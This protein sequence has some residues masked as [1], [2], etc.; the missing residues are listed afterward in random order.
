MYMEKNVYSTLAIYRHKKE[1]R[2]GEQTLTHYSKHMY[3]AAIEVKKIYMYIV[4]SD[5]LR[6][7]YNHHLGKHQMQHQGTEGFLKL[8]GLWELHTCS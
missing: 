7:R 2:H 4:I 8:Q 6:Q 3:S 1:S 5:G